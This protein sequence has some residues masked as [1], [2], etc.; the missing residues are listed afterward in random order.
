MFQYAGQSLGV[1]FGGAV[2]ATFATASGSALHSLPSPADMSSLA[3]DPAAQE[4]MGN[5]FIDGMQA[6]LFAIPLPGIGGV[7]SVL[8]SNPGQQL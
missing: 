5:A 3:S 4:A 8:H 7:L 2:F 1:A 6:A